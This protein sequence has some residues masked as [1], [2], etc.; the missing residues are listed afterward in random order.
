M[1]TSRAWHRSLLAHTLCRAGAGSV[2]VRRTARDHVRSRM[3]RHRRQE[4]RDVAG[5]GHRSGRLVGIVV[6]SRR[7]VDVR[8]EGEVRSGRREGHR[9]SRLEVVVGCDDDSRH[10]AGCSHE[11][12]H[13]GRSSRRLEVGRSHHGRGS[14]RASEIDSAHAGAG[15]QLEAAVGKHLDKCCLCRR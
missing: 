3:G 10:G 14:R 7:R 2:D 11:A 6:G 12:G 5:V 8:H 1:F 13:G 4:R 9:S 15:R